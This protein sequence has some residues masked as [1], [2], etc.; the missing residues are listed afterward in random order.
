MTPD[1]ST[2][3]NLVTARNSLSGQ[4]VSLAH[5][6]RTT[7]NTYASGARGS[8]NAAAA[9]SVSLIG[10]EPTDAEY[11]TAL[12]LVT[13]AEAF[14]AAAAAAQAV[15]GS[16]GNWRPAGSPVDAALREMNV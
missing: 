11:Q 10:T 9:A 3:H 1:T 2:A 16:P 7:V 6:A 5:N 14:L 13:A 8:L 4:L 12:A 15:V